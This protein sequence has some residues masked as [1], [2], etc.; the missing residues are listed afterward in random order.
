MSG[1]IDS[2]VSAYLLKKQGYEVEGVS[3][4]LYEGDSTPE[5]MSC[6]SSRSQCIFQSLQGASEAA[7]HLG[8]PHTIIDVRKD[9]TEK[10]IHPFIDEYL[11]GSTPNPCILCNRFIKFPFLIREAEKKG[12]EWISTGHYAKIEKIKNPCPGD[13]PGETESKSRILLKKGADVEKDQS[14]V[15]YS[16]AQKELR[17]LIF[18]LGGYRKNSVKAMALELN[19]PASKRNESQEIC[20]IKD[21]NYAHFIEQ[22]CSV[23][24]KPGPIMDIS[25]TVLGTHK[26]IYSYTVGQRKGLGISSPEPLYVLKI[27]TMENTIHV[28]PRQSAKKKDFLV[29]GVRWIIPPPSEKFLATVKVRSMMKDKPATLFLF[30]HTHPSTSWEKGNGGGARE[31][32]QVV[33]DAAQWAPAPGQSAV[34]YDGDVVLGG[35]III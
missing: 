11:R 1:G 18:P 24:G 30:H 13:S 20:F 22:F 16:L 10:V 15:L 31:I 17:R 26:G 7:S 35:G 19:L 4:V 33:F 2:S 12:A 29:T 8:I 21:R 27:D 25:G 14:Y 23:S 32:V 3:F 28:G 34:F 6:D 9:F 5:S